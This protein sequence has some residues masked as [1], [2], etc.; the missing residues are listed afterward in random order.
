LPLR[1]PIPAR[2]PILYVILG[3]LVA[4]SVV[5]MYFYSA[6][7]ESINRDRLKTN[8]MLLQNTV[9]RSLADDISQHEASLRMMLT[10]L[11]SAMQVASGADIGAG[12]VETP[13]LRALLENFVSSSE[14]VAYATLLN[15]QAK[16][17]SA[18]RIVP[19]AFLR[20]ELERGFAA[21]HEGRAYNGQA[22]VVGSGKSARTVILV[23]Y[24]IMNGGRFLGMIGSVVDLQF[25]IRRLEEV[26]RTGLTPYVVDAQ[27]RLVA[28]DRVDLVTGQD[29]KKFEIV[30]TFVDEGN[31]AQLAATKEFTVQ[32]GNQQI[33]MLGTYSPV[34]ALDWAVVVQKPRL[35]AYRGVYEMQHTARLL[36]LLAV[37]ASMIVSIYAARRITNPLEVLTESSRAIARGDF[38]KR[39]ELKSRTEIGELANT[40]N[41]MSE[42]LQ[43]FVEDLK[44]AAEENRALFMGSIQMLSGAVDEKDPYTRGHSDRVTRYSLLI[45]RE[46][47]LEDEFL[48]ILRISAQLHDVGKIGIEDHI[49]KKPGALTPEE[50]E[51]MKT[52]T[53]KGANILRPVKQLKEMLPGI[54]LHHEALDGRGYP[55]GLKGDQI[56]LLA[57]VIAVAD[58]FD[59][60]TTNRPYQ[61]AY[62]PQEALRIIHNLAGKRLD[63]ECIAALNAVYERGE[64]RIQRLVR[65]RVPA[66]PAALKPA[67]EPTALSAG[68]A[69]A[70]AAGTAPAPSPAMSAPQESTPPA[71]PVD[72]V[73]ETTRF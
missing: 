31:K 33:D 13:Q 38:S 16:G 1:L 29:M 55:Y 8:E 12:R 40:F 48:E 49:L 36:A 67:S 68:A 10:N 57:R 39:V 4:I 14:D 65:T 2:I 70:A 44:H 62:D 53:T 52:H 66:P 71:V 9:T 21:A 42:E 56:P 59:A 28:A 43:Q 47:K 32:D 3:V 25:L 63:P 50:F 58:T 19:D 34:T 45:A 24:P 5:P 46:M 41:T 72:A 61:R 64:I 27:G 69:A 20:R 18:G 22:L 35:E 11:A 23:S 30:H 15:S 60:L 73:V 17:V 37:L 26:T 54:E 51:I 7:V 6:Q